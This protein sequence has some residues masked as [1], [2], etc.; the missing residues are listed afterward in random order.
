MTGAKGKRLP[1]DIIQYN[2]RNA[3]RRDGNMT[4]RVY[5]GPAP[6]LFVLLA[7]LGLFPGILNEG[8]R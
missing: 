2:V 7:Y 6:W 3:Y 5:I 1:R 8:L 4:Y